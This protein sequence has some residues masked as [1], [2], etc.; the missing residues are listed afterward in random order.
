MV[1]GLDL[2][3]DENMVYAQRLLAA[4][5]PTEMH[6]YP[7]AYHGFHGYSPVAGVSKR[8]VAERDEVLK[9]VLHG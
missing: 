4:G 9:K 2:F 5:V 8:F 3:L 7:N 6:V 1:G